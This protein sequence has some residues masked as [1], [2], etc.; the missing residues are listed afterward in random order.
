MKNRANPEN[1]RSLNRKYLTT[2]KGKAARQRA[3][4]K[5]RENHKKKVKAHGMVAYALKTGALK[6]QPC[7]VCGDEKSQAHH[8]DYDNPLGVVWLCDKHHKE[9]HALV[10]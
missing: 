10:A 5:Y 2:E 7:H 6:K 4:I 3:Q 8:A 9:A 1:C